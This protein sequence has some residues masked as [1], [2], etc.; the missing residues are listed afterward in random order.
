MRRL[1]GDADPQRA[2]LGHGVPGI[3]DEVQEELIELARI[4]ADRHVR[5]RT[6][7]ELNPGWQHGLDQDPAAVDQSGRRY[8]RGVVRRVAGQRQQLPAQRDA[9][10]GGPAQQIQG[11]G[12][13]LGVRGVLDELGAAGNRGEDVVEL[14]GDAVGQPAG[15]LQL[16]RLDQAIGQVLPLDCVPH[17]A[18]HDV[19]IELSLDQP[20]LGAQLKGLACDVDV[21]DPGEHHDR[22]LGGRCEHGAQR[23]QARAVRK[24]QVE[25]HRVRAGPADLLE[26][27]HEVAHGLHDRRL[28]ARRQREAEERSERRVVLD[29]QYPK[30]RSRRHSGQAA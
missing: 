14:V 3:Q 6:D 5:D 19:G 27:P 2:P 29:Q 1:G 10:A 24:V 12:A 17:G 8:D 22:Q 23:R 25:H 16:L 18:L 7:L 30:T 13:G 26:R 28:R 21:G 15:D 9:L 11:A 4:E 20:V